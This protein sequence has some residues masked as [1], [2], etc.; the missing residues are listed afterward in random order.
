IEGESNEDILRSAVISLLG[1]MNLMLGKLNPTE[2]AIMDR[3]IWETYAKK[4][5]TPGSTLT[6]VDVPVMSDL[7]E[8]LGGMVGGESLAQRLTKYTEGTFSG[9]FNQQTNIN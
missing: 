4:D 8:I 9:I 3:A 2:E 6:N 5:I 1:L 7:V